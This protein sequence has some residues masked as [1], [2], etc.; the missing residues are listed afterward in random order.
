MSLTYYLRFLLGWYSLFKM[1]VHNAKTISSWRKNIKKINW[2]GHEKIEL[3]DQLACPAKGA[4][5]FGGPSQRWPQRE[6][7]NDGAIQPS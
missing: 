5:K 4:A 7:A 2:G 1:F 3:S 6:V